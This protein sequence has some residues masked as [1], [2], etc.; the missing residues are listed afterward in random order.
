MIEGGS[1]V[2]SSFLHAAPRADGTNVVDTVVVTVAPT[3]VG[4]GVG[5]VPLV[6]PLLRSCYPVGEADKIGSGHWI[7]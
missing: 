2:L 1:K 3:F 6:C 7:T 5:V 4:E